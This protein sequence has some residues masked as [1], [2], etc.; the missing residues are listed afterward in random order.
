M[1]DGPLDAPAQTVGL[2]IDDLEISGGIEHLCLLNRSRYV[3]IPLLARQRCKRDWIVKLIGKNFVSQILVVAATSQ[4]GQSLAD[5][6]LG[7][8]CAFAQPEPRTKRGANSTH[9]V[10]RHHEAPVREGTPSRA[11][12]GACSVGL[13]DGL[14]KIRGFR[15]S[16]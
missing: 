1:N 5:G 13:S 4:F 9:P 15:D 3:G 7:H 14:G 12:A 8:E 6:V 10:P 11:L 16:P 2:A